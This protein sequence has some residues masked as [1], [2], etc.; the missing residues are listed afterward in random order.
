MQLFPF[1]PLHTALIASRSFALGSV[2]DLLRPYG[3]L[4]TI[5][6][7]TPQ[8]ALSPRFALVSFT[9][10]HSS[11]AAV[12]CL[13]GLSVP[14][15]PPRVVTISSTPSATPLPNPSS[16]SPATLTRM[17]FSYVSPLKAHVVRDWISGHPKIALP[18]LFFLVGTLSYTAS[19][20]NLNLRETCTD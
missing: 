12:S 1:I 16:N 2:F 19:R 4:S 18:F 20:I 13:H 10:L 5:T 9:R 7:P 17:S 6:P 14:P 3:H 15:T 8:P 11:T